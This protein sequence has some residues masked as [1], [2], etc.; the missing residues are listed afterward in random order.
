MKSIAI[1]AWSPNANRSISNDWNKYS[2]ISKNKKNKLSFGDD[3]FLFV[4]SLEIDIEGFFSNDSSKSNSG[5][6]S[7]KLNYFI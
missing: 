6:F 5:A 3:E 2:I 1:A 7:S 4:S